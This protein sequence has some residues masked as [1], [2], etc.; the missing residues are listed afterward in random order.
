MNLI[1]VFLNKLKDLDK[2]K[3]E[4]HVIGPFTY[5]KQQ[6]KKDQN[7]YVVSECVWSFNAELKW[8]LHCEDCP[9]ILKEHTLHLILHYSDF[10]DRDLR[11]ISIA[12]ELKKTGGEKKH[13]I[14]WCMLNG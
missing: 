4:C 9:F 2:K 10:P 8:V 13:L 6:F 3:D 11:L 1:Y 5:D 7:H 14:L 12:T